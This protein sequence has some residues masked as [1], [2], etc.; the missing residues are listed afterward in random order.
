MRR[1][2]STRKKAGITSEKTRAGG[3]ER[4]AY[5]D[6]DGRRTS[7]GVER[8]RRGAQVVGERKSYSMKRRAEGEE[9]AREKREA[10]GR[11]IR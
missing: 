7:Y 4:E 3:G 8:W 1:N 6:E 9:T 2:M 10:G 5:G 11:V